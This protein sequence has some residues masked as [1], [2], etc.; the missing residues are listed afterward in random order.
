[1]TKSEPPSA[2]QLFEQLAARL[3]ADPAV[4]RGTGFGSSPGL[5]VGGKTFAMLR[6]G[7]LVVKLPKEQVDQLVL[8]GKGGRFDPRRDGRLMREW[9]TIVGRRRS[10]WEQLASQAR[11]FVRQ[12]R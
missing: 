2:E 7:E 4:S 1:M 11:E 9:V 6:G 3:L 5:R 8:S 12:A 10:L